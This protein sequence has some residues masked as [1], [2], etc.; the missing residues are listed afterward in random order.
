MQDQDGSN[1]FIRVWTFDLG[2][3]KFAIS[4]KSLRQHMHQC[5]LNQFRYH[6][7]MKCFK[8]GRC[9]DL[10]VE[11]IMDGQVVVNDDA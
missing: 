5:D 11:S 1:I 10:D 6:A 4:F 7:T 2:E 9:C 3:I 8:E